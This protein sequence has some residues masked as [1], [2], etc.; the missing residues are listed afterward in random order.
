VRCVDVGWSAHGG[1][2]EGECGDGGAGGDGEVVVE[3]A[4][5]DGGLVPR[6]FPLHRTLAQPP[7][8]A[9]TKSREDPSNAMAKAEVDMR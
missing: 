9:L 5:R 8:E 2:A 6:R 3:G 7:V 1:V 4:R